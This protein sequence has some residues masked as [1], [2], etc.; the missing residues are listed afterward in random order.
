MDGILEQI[1]TE[2]K[3]IKQILK[4]KEGLCDETNLGKPFHDTMNVKE[5]AEYL[6]ITAD[7]LRT[8]SKQGKIRH[9]KAGNRFLFKR[10]SLDAWLKETLE[11]SIQKSEVKV[12]NGRIRRI[13]V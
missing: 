11:A 9:L 10:V 1:L 5:A 7:R 3:E 8:L 2:L 12:G 4:A 6:G 13:D